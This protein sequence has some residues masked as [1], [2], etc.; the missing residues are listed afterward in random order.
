MG[1][2]KKSQAMAT[3]SAKRLIWEIP[4][5]SPSGRGHMPEAGGDQ[6]RTLLNVIRRKGIQVTP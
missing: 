1:P 6:H 2:E 3:I 5:G 4:F